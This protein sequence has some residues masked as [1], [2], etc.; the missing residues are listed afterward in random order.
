[1]DE[2]TYDLSF[3]YAVVNLD[4]QL[5]VDEAQLLTDVLGLAVCPLLFKNDSD[6]HAKASRSGSG[7]V[8]GIRAVKNKDP[9]VPVLC[10]SERQGHGVENHPAVL[11]LCPLE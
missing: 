1:M 10:L 4:E 11:V 9:V 6:R 5:D 8:Y 3:V 2:C 7:I